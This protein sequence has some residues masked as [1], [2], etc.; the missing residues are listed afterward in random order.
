[1]QIQFEKGQQRSLFEYSMQ[2]LKLN[3]REFGDKFGVDYELMKKYHQE[4]CLIPE[5]LY[6]RICKIIEISPKSLRVSYLER[7]WGQIIGGRRGYQTLR[8]KYGKYFAEWRVK[9]G[10]KKWA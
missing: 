1:M 9:G 7:N 6:L 5:K 10:R 4:K 8:E 2:H 3:L